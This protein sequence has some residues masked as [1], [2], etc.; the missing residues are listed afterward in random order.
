[1]KKNLGGIHFSFTAVLAFGVLAASCLVGS[2]YSLAQPNDNAGAWPQFRGPAFNPTAENPQLPEKWSNTENV[3][4]AINIDGRGWS[5]P[6]VVGNQVFVT[7]VTT[8]GDSK[9]PQT[10][11][12]YSNEYV[13]E[14][15]KQGLSEEE[16]ERKVMERDFELPDQVSLHYFLMC[17]DLQSGKELWKQEYY[18]GQPPGGRHRKNSFSSE[19]PVTD[20]NKIYVYATHL[21]LYAYDLD[22]QPAWKTELSNH[23]IYMEF[24]TGSSPVL[25][26]G[27]VVIVDDNQEQS[28]ITA[29]DTST[30]KQ[31]WQTERLVPEGFPANMPRSGWSTPYIWQNELRTEIVT[32]GPGMAVSYDTNGKE[33]WRLNG[34]TP[35]PSSSS[36]AVDEMLYLNGGRGKPFF[37]VRP[38]ASGDISLESGQQS[39]D[40]VAWT[41]SRVGT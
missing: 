20:G 11:V 8:E 4:W 28:T 24:G 17:Y 38:G 3:E 41:R 18:Q 9:E 36:F 13:E 1:M 7:T 12:N 30:G 40:H 23:P 25:V 35:A 22:G 27:K 15:S 5:S 37:A 39:N 2:R 21:G 26:D 19:T 31:V 34:L 14:L 6:I 32:V 16:I 29:Y 33:L 10:G